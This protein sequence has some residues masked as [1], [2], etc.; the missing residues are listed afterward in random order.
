[1]IDLTFEIEA[2]AD[3]VGGDDVVDVAV[4]IEIDLGIARART[5]CA[6]HDGRAAALPAH[7]FSD[8][9]DLFRRERDDRAAR[10]QP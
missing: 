6:E 9:I 7:E 4:L 1:M 2:H 3:R 5:E 8:R 10:R